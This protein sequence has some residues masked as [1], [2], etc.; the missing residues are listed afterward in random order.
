MYQ[1]H[2]ALLPSKLTFIKFLSLKLNVKKKTT[3][4]LVQMLI[5]KRQRIFIEIVRYIIQ[6]KVE[7]WILI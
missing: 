6:F 4:L 5:L 7:N 2:M 1:H 3:S